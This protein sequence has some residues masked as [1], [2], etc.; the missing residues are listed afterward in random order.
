MAS[1]NAKQARPRKD[2]PSTRVFAIRSPASRVCSEVK[3]MASPMGRSVA[4]QASS[5]RSPSIDKFTVHFRQIYRAG[6]CGAQK[7]GR[8]LVSTRLLVENG[9]QCGSVQH[10]P[11]HYGPTRDV[12]RSIRP[13]EMHRANAQFV[14]LNTLKTTSSTRI[15]NRLRK[16][17]GI[18][19]RPFLVDPRAGAECH[20][21]IV[22]Y[23]LALLPTCE[24][25]TTVRITACGL[26]LYK[27]V[28]RGGLT[29]LT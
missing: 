29:P 18:T 7:L 9:K 17:A 1:P 14:V 11:I 22:T 24:R 5:G 20:Q 16:A 26:G 21:S 2:Q 23:S 10:N 12:P 25:G 6:S 4:S 28:F 15:P 8:Q 13:A 19:M 27:A 3:G